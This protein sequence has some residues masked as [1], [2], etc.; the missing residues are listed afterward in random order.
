[1]DY[2]KIFTEFEYKTSRSSGPGGQHV[3]KT[4]TRIEIHLNLVKSDA[5]TKDEKIRLTQKLINRM[6]SDGRIIVYSEASRSQHKNK[7]DAEN[8]MLELISLNLK[9]TKKRIPTRPNRKSIEQRL[10]NKKRRSEVK[11]SRKA[12][13][14]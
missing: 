5:F 11:T 10:K 13:D 7:I 14:L 2:N 6:T 4:E 12:P 3:N 8:K 1:M 9:R